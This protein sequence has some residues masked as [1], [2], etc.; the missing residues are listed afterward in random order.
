MVFPR[1]IIFY[2]TRQP[3]RY[4]LKKIKNFCS[5]FCVVMMFVTGC[6]RIPPENNY[7]GMSKPEVAAHLEK[8]AERTRWSKDRFAIEISV[9]GIASPYWFGNEKEVSACSPVMSAQQWRC[10]FFPKRHWLLGWNSLAASWHYKTLFFQNGKVVKQESGTLPYKTYGVGGDSPFP[11]IPKNFHQV[12]ENIYR[13]NQPDDE[14]F[15]S[16]YTFN[17]IR[18]VLN[19]REYNSNKDE[20]RTVNRKALS[21]PPT[22]L[23]ICLPGFIGAFLLF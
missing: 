22:T 6:Q 15:E 7:I 19:L 9:N 23:I 20:I 4:I 10:D 18:S 11:Q 13:S 3:R 14:E 16:L 2:N 12:S 1:K 5:I 8:H 17:G 21:H